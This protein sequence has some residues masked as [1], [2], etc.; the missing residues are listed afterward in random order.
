MAFDFKKEYKE[1]YKPKNT[2]IRLPDF[3]TREDF[4]WAVQEATKKKK[5]DFDINGE[6][7]NMLQNTGQRR[8]A[9]LPGIFPGSVITRA[10]P[11]Q[12]AYRRNADY[13]MSGSR[14][15]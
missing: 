9:V 10:T 6:P 2:V 1:F 13:V 4:D 12:S 15:T 5:T 7:H 8:F 11:S 14:K 3:V